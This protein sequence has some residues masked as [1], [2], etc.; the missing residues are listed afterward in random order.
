MT[1][2]RET[3][4]TALALQVVQ[5]IGHMSDGGYICREIGRELPGVFI[6]QPYQMATEWRAA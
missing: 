3:T 6:A 4:R 2:P 1:R 5:I